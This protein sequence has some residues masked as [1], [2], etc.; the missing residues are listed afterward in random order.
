MSNSERVV[1]WRGLNSDP[2]QFGEFGNTCLTSEATKT[3]TLH[4][5]KRHLSFIM[6]GGAVDVADAAFDLT[7]HIHSTSNIAPK[8]SG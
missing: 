2:T 6:Y 4:T 5:P 1:A 3:T 8:D 7:S